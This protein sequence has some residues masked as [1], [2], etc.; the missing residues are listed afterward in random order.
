MAGQMLTPRL[1]DARAGSRAGATSNGGEVPAENLESFKCVNTQMI[2]HNPAD[3]PSSIVARAHRTAALAAAVT[4]A[5]CL[6]LV[7]LE[8]IGKHIEEGAPR[9]IPEAWAKLPVGTAN[10]VWAVSVAYYTALH[11]VVDLWRRYGFSDDRTARLL[12][13]SEHKDLLRDFRNAMLHPQRL[14]D[15]RISR[16]TARGREYLDWSDALLDSLDGYFRER[17]VRTQE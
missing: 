13:G 1:A 14:T 2:N 3:L 8:E 17:F 6:R 16:L 10:R 7:L 11:V 12:E 15:S 4:S 5:K 9:P